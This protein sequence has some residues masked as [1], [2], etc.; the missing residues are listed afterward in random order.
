M[1]IHMKV[2]REKLKSIILEEINNNNLW[3]NEI[4]RRLVRRGIDCSLTTVWNIVNE[5]KEEGLVIIE[6]V[7]NVS[8]VRRREN[9]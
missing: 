1:F 6:R 4:H 2:E 7:G 5:L 3:I 8:L 9:A